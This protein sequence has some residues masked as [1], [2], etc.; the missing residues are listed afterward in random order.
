MLQIIF[1]FSEMGGVSYLV[2]QPYIDNVCSHRVRKVLNKRKVV[3]PDCHWPRD[4]GAEINKYSLLSLR[5]CH[6]SHRK[7]IGTRGVGM[8]SK[9]GELPSDIKNVTRGMAA[10]VENMSLVFSTHVVAHNYL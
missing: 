8:L 9:G 5:K 10:L 4:T 6:V 3:I 1:N 2:N 7:C